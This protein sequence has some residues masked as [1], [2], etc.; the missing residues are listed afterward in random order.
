MSANQGG[1]YAF[2]PV[3]LTPQEAM[4][5]YDSLPPAFRDLLRNAPLNLNLTAYSSDPD[6]IRGRISVK[7]REATLETYGPDHPQAG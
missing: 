1:A 4:S 7:M 5:Y 6:Y 3:A 2:K